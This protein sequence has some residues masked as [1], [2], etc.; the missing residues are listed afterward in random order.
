MISTT[1]TKEM[2][3]CKSNGRFWAKGGDVHGDQIVK[4]EGEG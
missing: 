4:K 3:V 2:M 1:L